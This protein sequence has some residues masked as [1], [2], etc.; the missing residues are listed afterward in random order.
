[1]HCVYSGLDYS[2]MEST[3]SLLDAHIPK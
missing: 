1:V 2:G 3:H